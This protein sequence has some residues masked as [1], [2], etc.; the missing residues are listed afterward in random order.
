MNTKQLRQ[1]MLDPLPLRNLNPHY[2]KYTDER[3]PFLGFYL[4]FCHALLRL[5]DFL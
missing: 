2:R 3:S 4:Y 5:F 1:K